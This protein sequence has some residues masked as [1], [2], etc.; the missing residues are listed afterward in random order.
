MQ[1]TTHVSIVI[2]KEQST[3]SPYESQTQIAATRVEAN[4]VSHR[5]SGRAGETPAV[6]ID[7]RKVRHS[8]HSPTT[9]EPVFACAVKHSRLCA[10]PGAN[11][12]VIAAGYT[13]MMLFE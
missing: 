5:L 10:Y 3:V 13:T 2:G 11:G 6:E 8:S 4:N 12:I 7:V 9:Y 1:G